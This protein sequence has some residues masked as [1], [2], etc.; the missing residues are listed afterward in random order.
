MLARLP[1][2][3]LSLSAA[4]S[5]AKTGERSAALVGTPAQESEPSQ[6]LYRAQDSEHVQ[7]TLAVLRARV[8]GMAGDVRVQAEAGNIA[9]SF[10]NLGVREQAALHDL[11]TRP[12]TLA[13]K[14]IESAAPFMEELCQRVRADSKA[15]VLN[16]ETALDTWQDP[17]GQVHRDCYLSADDRGAML[18]AEEA[19]I[20]GCSVTNPKG[21]SHCTVSGRHI[22]E[23]YLA[24]RGDVEPDEGFEIAYEAAVSSAIED[25]GGERFWRTYYQRSVAEIDERRLRDAR[26]QMSSEDD[27]ALVLEFDEEGKETLATLTGEQLGRKLSIMIDGQVHSAPVIHSAVSGGSV[28]LTSEQGTPTERETKAREHARVLNSGP[29]PTPL[30]RIDAR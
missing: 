7:A 1:V 27:P 12:G 21:R 16:I 4:C 10:A 25:D 14:R 5:A 22:L 19:R 11:I 24:D 6:V 8:Q 13:I 26:V 9:V 3:L 17:S 2:L 20:E 30:T 18:N 29:L 23:R 28:M 15:G